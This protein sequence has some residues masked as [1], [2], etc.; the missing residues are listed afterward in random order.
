[1]IK[2]IKINNSGAYVP[3][4]PFLFRSNESIVSSSV[5]FSFDCPSLSL[6]GETELSFD[7]LI[8]NFLAPNS[9][10]FN[11]VRV[12]CIEVA[13]EDE[14]DGGEGNLYL[15]IALFFFFLETSVTTPVNILYSSLLCIEA[16]G[17]GT[18]LRS[19]SVHSSAD[20]ADHDDEAES[21]SELHITTGNG[22]LHFL[23]DVFKRSSR[24][25]INNY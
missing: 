16:D 10:I 25:L 5:T 14:G 21:D 12:E 1:M 3:R 20:L 18:G 19:S 8:D 22:K 7:I 4:F 11:A 9:I 13:D 15:P 17:L 2:T 6:C 23:P 24:Y